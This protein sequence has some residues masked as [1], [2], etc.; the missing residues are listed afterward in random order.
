MPHATDVSVVQNASNIVWNEVVPF[1]LIRT[2]FNTLGYFYWAI[3]M[4]GFSVNGTNLTPM[5]M[6][7]TST[8]DSSITGRWDSWDLRSVPGCRRYHSVHKAN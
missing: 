3:C 7:P 5:P 6:Y 8:D 4:T 2:Q 1:S